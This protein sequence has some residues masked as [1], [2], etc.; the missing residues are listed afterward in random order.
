MLQ[1]T[2]SATTSNTVWIDQ[3]SFPYGKLALALTSSYSGQTKDVISDRDW[4]T[5]LVYPNS[6]TCSCGSS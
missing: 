1:L 4:E 6:I 5:C 2:T 3:T